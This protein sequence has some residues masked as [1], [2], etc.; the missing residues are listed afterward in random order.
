MMLIGLKKHIVECYRESGALDF[1]VAGLVASGTRSIGRIDR[2]R[3][4]IERLIEK[5]GNLGFTL[6]ANN[7]PT[8]TLE[9][10]VDFFQQLQI[11]TGREYRPQYLLHRIQGSE[12]RMEAD[13]LGLA[14][15]FNMVAYAAGVTDLGIAVA[16]RHYFPCYALKAS[17]ANTLSF[18]LRQISPQRLQVLLRQKK[19]YGQRDLVAMLAARTAGRLYNGG[20]QLTADRFYEFAGA[21]A[22]EQSL[23]EKELEYGQAASSQRNMPDV[24]YV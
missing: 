17:P 8:G 20:C 15:V 3:R 21:L 16:G 11:G 2:A 18:P 9:T 24:K 7:A 22:S 14:A 19:V 5:M 1:P 6:H 4:N 23:V 13:R 10:I 12:S